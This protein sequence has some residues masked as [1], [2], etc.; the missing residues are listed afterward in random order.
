MNVRLSL[1]YPYVASFSDMSN[2][3]VALYNLLL[4]H[5]NPL[6]YSPHEQECSFVNC[7][8]ALEIPLDLQISSNYLD[9]VYMIV[10]TF[11]NP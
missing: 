1:S 3:E 4:T 6:Q 11:L 10:R 5:Q 2:Q 7:Q 8:V 9:M